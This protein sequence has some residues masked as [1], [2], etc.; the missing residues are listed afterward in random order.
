MSET[1]NNLLQVEI[2]GKKKQVY[3]DIDGT[4]LPVFIKEGGELF[5]RLSGGGDIVDIKPHY[6]N[7]LYIVKDFVRKESEEICGLDPESLKT[8]TFYKYNGNFISCKKIN[9]FQIQDY[10]YSGRKEPSKRTYKTN[11]E[12]S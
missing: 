2:D 3:Y 11:E 10:G 4:K 1:S 8:Q 9:N 5:C 12:R 6:N 7:K